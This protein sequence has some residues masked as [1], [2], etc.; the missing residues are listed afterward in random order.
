MPTPGPGGTVTPVSGKLL[1]YSW[2]NTLG[3]FETTFRPSTGQFSPGLPI[4]PPEPEPTRAW[5]F[6][7]AYNTVWTPRS[8]EPVTFYELRA[9]AENYDI[10]RLCIETR[11]DQIEKLE[12]QIKPRDDEN[13]T[14]DA[15]KRADQQHEFWERPDGEHSFSTWLRI[16][17]EDVLVLDAPAFEIRRQRDGQ[18]IGLD[19]VDGS[20]IKLLVDY[21]GRRPQAPAPAFEQIIHGRPWRLLTA[22]ELLY[23]PRNPRPHKVYG[24]GPV[25]QI[26]AL[27]NIGIRREIMQLQHFTES[28]V[29]AGL[30]NSPDGW[31]PEQI[32]SFQAW[33]DD[34]L[35][36]NTGNRTRLMWGPFGSKYQAFKEAPFKDG[37]D[38]WLARIVCYAFSLPPTP[39]VEKSP[40]RSSSETLQEAALAE[41]LAPLMGWVKR[42]V[43]LRHSDQDGSARPGIQLEDGRDVAAGN[44]SGGDRQISAQRH[45]CGERSSRSARYGS[46]RGRRRSDDLS[47]HRSRSSSRAS[48]TRPIWRPS[49]NS[50]RWMARSRPRI[51][52]RICIPARWRRQS[53]R[54]PIPRPKPKP[55]GRCARSS[56]LRR[57][58]D[59]ISIAP[60]RAAALRRK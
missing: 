33:F 1:Q 2:G 13:P 23:M 21:N 41:G 48:R 34:L 15:Q 10:L 46:R 44:R 20:T 38:E 54:K 29:P 56:R 51:N 59:W 19:H 5:N 45:L 25:E 16:A 30:L 24:F 3:G 58:G 47:A 6:P 40:N 52:P 11:K 14:A 7:F 37:F 39:F 31:T 28:N 26:I 9:L 50:W 27:V 32:A 60:I 35:S 55:P 42:I 8:F 12:F 18:I 57:N 49:S 36:G 53:F 17:L 4:V 43:R 22:D